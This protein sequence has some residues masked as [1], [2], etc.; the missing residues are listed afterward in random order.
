MTTADVLIVGASAG[1]LA[2][3]EGLRRRGFTGSIALV[4]AERELPYDRP[5][6]SKQVLDGRWSPDRTRLRGR[7]ELD[8]LELDLLLGRPAL[9]LDVAGHRVGLRGGGELGY[10]KLVVATGLSARRLPGQTGL[11]GVHTLRTLEEAA[12]LR[13]D[14]LAAR[15]V[16]VVGAGVLGCEIAATARGL[17]REVTVLDPAAHPMEHLLGPEIGGAL[18]RLHRDHGVS[19]RT[20][21]PVRGLIQEQGRVVGVRTGAGS[22]VPADVVVVAVGGRPATDWLA[23]SGLGLDDGVVCDHRCRAAADVYAV[24]DVA[25]FGAQGSAGRGTRLENRTNATEQGVF[26]AGDI[27]GADAHYRPVPYFWSDQ[28][29]VRLQVYGTVPGHSSVRIVEGSPGG[30]AFVAHVE[31]GGRLVGVIGW[32]SAR[33][34]RTAKALLTAAARSDEPAVGAPSALSHHTSPAELPTEGD[35]L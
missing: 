24:G 12:K 28:Y 30:G 18:G 1:G 33:R 11:S 23:G 13:A 21:T 17:G 35:L 2:V 5:P 26:V 32:N 15:R 29:Q 6:L 20:S 10:R 8:E 3:A 9:S 19:V 7:A 27:L 34:T 16:V 22:S 14:L 31:S 25:R 4:G